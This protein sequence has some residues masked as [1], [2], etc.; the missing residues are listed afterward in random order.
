MVPITG[1]VRLTTF[2]KT[3]LNILLMEIPY[4][5]LRGHLVAQNNLIWIFKIGC[6]YLHILLIKNGLILIVIVAKFQLYVNG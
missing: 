3:K 2:Q 5:S 4:P 6:A 1:L